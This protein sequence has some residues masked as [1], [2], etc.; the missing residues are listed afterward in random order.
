MDMPERIGSYKVVR[1][2]G[3]GLM[4][5][6]YMGVQENSYWALRVMSDANVRST[7][8]VAKLVGD[9]IHDAVVRYKE[10][11]T[12]STV[13]AFIST[14][15]VEAKPLSRDGLAGMRSKERMQFIIHLLGGLEELHKRG[16]IHGSIKPSNV[17]LR[18]PK[19]SQQ[20]HG[21]FIDSGFMYAPQ[22]QHL[23]KFISSV[24]PYLAPEV[25]EAYASG[26][27]S[28]IEE[29]LTPKAD[30]YSVGLLVAETLSGR[31]LFFG[32]RS[33]E[34]LLHRKRNSTVEITG[35]NDPLEH[36]R[37]QA[38][39]SAVRKV[40]HHDPHQR[41]ASIVELRATLLE[42]IPENKSSVA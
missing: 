37:M 11:G 15:F 34:E 10:V 38:A 22:E 24:F 39:N 6:V 3:S 13:G 23:H 17:L 36:L 2:L 12:D 33:I 28:R 16:A 26:D 9:P 5:D 27:R 25:I 7:S 30:I 31:R 8:S 18:R 29:A 20:A 1:K 41:P 4:G 32:S 42:S 19:S 40:T 14:D 21:L 35:L